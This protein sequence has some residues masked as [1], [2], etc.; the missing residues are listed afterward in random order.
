[1]ER[2]TCAFFQLGE[3]RSYQKRSS[4]NYGNVFSRRLEKDIAVRHP[5][6]VLLRADALRRGPVLATTRRFASPRPC[7]RGTASLY[8]IKP[9]GFL[10]ELARQRIPVLLYICLFQI[11]ILREQL[12]SSRTVSKL[13]NDDRDGNSHSPNAGSPTHDGRIKCDAI[14]RHSYSIM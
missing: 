3:R 7:R 4:T 9:E 11:R 2:E 12:L 14:E 10:P 13:A 6:V 5:A 8:L 1:M